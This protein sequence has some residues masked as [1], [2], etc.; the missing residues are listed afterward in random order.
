VPGC[1]H[2]REAATEAEADHAHLPGALRPI[3]KPGARGVEIIERA[4]RSGHRGAHRR[5]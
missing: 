5:Q 2:E 3:D 4:S 1:E